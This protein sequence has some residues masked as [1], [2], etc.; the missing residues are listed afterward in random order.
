MASSCQPTEPIH[1]EP[2]IVDSSTGHEEAPA[3]KPEGEANPELPK[4]ES[5]VQETLPERTRIF[6]RFP[7]NNRRNTGRYYS[8]SPIREIIREERIVTQT[9]FPER[10]ALLSTSDL[11]SLLSSSTADAL[12]EAYRGQ[13]TYVVT[14]PFHETDVQKLSWLFWLGKVDS[15]VTRPANFD[16]GAGNGDGNMAFDLA[17]ASG[18]YRDREI[19]RYDDRYDRAEIPIVRLGHALRVFPS[20]EEAASETSRVKFLIVIGSKSTSETVKLVVSYSRE[21]AMAQIVYEVLNGYSILFVGAVLRD[22]VVPTGFS[23]RRP[24]VKFSRVGS[25]REAEEIG[26]GV[27]GIIC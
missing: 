16:A 10:P 1:S 22:M 12:V 6:E 8:P 5:G 3:S 23:Y 15:W 14:H 18:G 2:V 19:I 11:E 17:P 21:A 9:N 7:R 25:L 24:V 26:E 27:V 4:D 20:S 13:M